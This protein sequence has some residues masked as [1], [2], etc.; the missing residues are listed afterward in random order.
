MC[1][2]FYDGEEHQATDFSEAQDSDAFAWDSKG[3][4]ARMLAQSAVVQRMD[5]G[6]LGMGAVHGTEDGEAEGF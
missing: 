2:L 5:E 1:Q 4:D 6:D 3:K